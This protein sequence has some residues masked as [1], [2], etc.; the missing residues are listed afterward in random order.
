MIALPSVN[1]LRAE[2][3]AVFRKHSVTLRT[4]P[5]PLLEPELR[6]CLF[7]IMNEALAVLST[8]FGEETFEAVRGELYEIVQ[9]DKAHLDLPDLVV[10][11]GQL[12]LTLEGFRLKLGVDTSTIDRLVLSG[13]TATADVKALVAAEL[14]RQG[15]TG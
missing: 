11:L 1:P 6:Q 15:W 9:I 13:A 14:R 8:V 12:G 7:A 2:I 4:E 5:G 10:A 3:L